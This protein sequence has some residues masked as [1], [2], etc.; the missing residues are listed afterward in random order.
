MFDVSREVLGQRNF[1]IEFALV[2]ELQD[3]VGE[4]DFAERG[5]WE[6]RLS[7][8]SFG[9]FRI[10]DAKRSRPS[11]LS[12]VDRSDGKARHLGGIHQIQNL[13]RKLFGTSVVLCQS[14]VGNQRDERDD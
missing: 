6:D 10:L 7:V 13:L 1:E 8:N 12:V 5:R 14:G 4:Y 2:H 11:D 3:A 9:G